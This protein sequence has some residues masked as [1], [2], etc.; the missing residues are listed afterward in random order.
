MSKMTSFAWE[1]NR[2]SPSVP[3]P[4]ILGTNRFLELVLDGSVQP[5][6]GD[7]V[8]WGHGWSGEGS[9]LA[10]LGEKGGCSLILTY[11]KKSFLLKDC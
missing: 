4:A 3:P 9:R 2:F 1:Q 5:E 10:R 8:R 11:Q 6:A 7:A